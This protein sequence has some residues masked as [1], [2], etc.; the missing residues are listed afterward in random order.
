MVLV[1][2]PVVV[3]GRV[4]RRS[5]TAVGTPQVGGGSFIG[6]G[7]LS[8]FRT[9]NGRSFGSAAVSISTCSSPSLTI[10][11]TDGH[12]LVRGAMAIGVA[13]RV[14]AGKIVRWFV[15]VVSPST[16]GTGLIAKR[17]MAAAYGTSEAGITR[18]GGSA[19]RSSSGGTALE[20]RSDPIRSGRDHHGPHAGCVVGV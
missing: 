16:I 19:A 3:Y 15:A 11:D 18:G 8:L 2:R 12:S 13:S 10:G 7:P 4:G 17:V 9:A 6:I 20:Q 14:R 5:S 1:G